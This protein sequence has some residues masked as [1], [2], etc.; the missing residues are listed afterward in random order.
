MEQQAQ[1]R[2]AAVLAVDVAG[3]TRLMRVDEDTEIA[4]VHVFLR[5]GWSC[6]ELVDIWNR[7]IAPGG[8]R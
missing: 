8:V 3:Y 1:R 5:V 7:R 2:L 6:S 4:V